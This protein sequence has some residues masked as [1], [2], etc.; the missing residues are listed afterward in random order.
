MVDEVMSVKENDKEK[1]YT[2]S[3]ALKQIEA[4]KRCGPTCNLAQTRRRRRR[5][6]L[7]AFCMHL[8]DLQRY[9][10]IANSTCSTSPGLPRRAPRPARVPPRPLSSASEPM[11]IRL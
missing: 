4:K 1:Q 9:R 7:A 3:G 11:K 8:M 5:R 2:V 10:R 6:R